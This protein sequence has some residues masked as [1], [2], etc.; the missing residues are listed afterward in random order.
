MVS[1]RSTFP[2]SLSP[3]RPPCSYSPSAVSRYSHVGF[4]VSD[5]RSDGGHGPTTSRRTRHRIDFNPAIVTDGGLS[6]HSSGCLL[7][8]VRRELGLVRRLSEQ[9][10]PIGL[11]HG[12][13]GC[14]RR[15][16]GGQKIS[17]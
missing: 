8:I 1:T 2:P 9:I 10:L 15:I 3:S 12:R 17:R 14:G 13:C 7:Q 5:L 11:I 16:G 6:L 4:G